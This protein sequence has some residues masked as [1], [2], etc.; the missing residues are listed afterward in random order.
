MSTDET[1]YAFPQTII[2]D[3]KNKRDSYYTDDNVTIIKQD[4]DLKIANKSIYSGEQK[5]DIMF[6][7]TE[8]GQF[9]YMDVGRWGGD[10]DTCNAWTRRRDFGLVC[11][12]AAILCTYKNPNTSVDHYLGSISD[13][14]LHC[15]E[16]LKMIPLL[17]K[18]SECNSLGPVTV[19][20]ALVC[21]DKTSEA[22]NTSEI[23]VF[24]GDI[25]APV[26][27]F[28][29]RTYLQDPLI[30][31]SWAYLR[32]RI[33]PNILAKDETKFSDEMT[34]LSREIAATELKPKEIDPI[35]ALVKL[36]KMS[37]KSQSVK[38]WDNKKV[39]GDDAQKWYDNYEE[40]DIFQSA[41]QDLEN[42]LK[43]LSDYKKMNL[44]PQAKLIQLGDLYEFWIG[45]QWVLNYTTQPSSMSSVQNFLQFWRHE[46]L[47]NTSASPSISYLLNNTQD[48]NPVFIY[49]NHDNCK[50]TSQWKY[51][52]CYEKYIPTGIW[53]E[54]GHQGDVFNQDSNAIIGWTCA[55]L[56]GI[57][58]PSLRILEDP[59]RTAEN[60]VFR[61]L[62]QRLIHILRAA[63]LCQQENQ[64]RA[65]TP[66]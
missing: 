46:I 43:L 8:L 23:L 3:Y 33:D 59:I 34:K 52:K 1:K 15:P 31:T 63:Y 22:P 53:A 5:E 2:D 13:D 10:Y 20:G 61:T 27:T 51:E 35:P 49:G 55:Q 66:T 50:A 48:L 62:C 36:L 64:L 56:G 9:I 58:D 21:T 41:G 60:W 28:R 16:V 54:H 29:D 38:S 11:G 39:S 18:L 17:N 30:S 65:T 57:F 45:L 47:N 25:H 12:S 4:S 19:M 14:V 42:F 40:A 6:G 37:L 24:L 7:S 26:M 32:D 44:I